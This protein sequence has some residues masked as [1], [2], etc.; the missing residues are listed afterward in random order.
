M[1]TYA[2][3]RNAVNK[4][5]FYRII[6]MS[7][8]IILLGSL[9]IAGC[10]VI[11]TSAQ[12][13]YNMNLIN[14]TYNDK[15]YKVAISDRLKQILVKDEIDNVSDNSSYTNEQKFKKIA[16]DYLSKHSPGCKTNNNS[17]KCSNGG[18]YE[19][20]YSCVPVPNSIVYPKVEPQK[21]FDAS[22][23]MPRHDDEYITKSKI[24][25]K[26]Y[27]LDMHRCEI[28]KSLGEP[29]LNFSIAGIVGKPILDFIDDRLAGF[30]FSYPSSDFK[31]V[32]NA[33]KSKYPELKCKESEIHNAMNAKFNQIECSL[34]FDNGSLILD[35]YTSNVS[36]GVLALISNARLQ[37][38]EK[39]R[40][41]RSKDI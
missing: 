14:T 11:G 23:C 32:Y 34:K 8:S 10:S 28:E 27:Y 6:I 25:I 26:G 12:S 1:Q 3:E 15:I 31:N 5:G 16:D 24:N 22:L 17:D 13:K 18:C 4:Q 29:D 21:V 39:K 40:L 19:F 2:E 7:K 20:E 9:I 35:K 33:V 30:I 41:Q 37:E 38:D 36:N